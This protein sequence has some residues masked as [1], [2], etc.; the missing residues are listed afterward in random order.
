MLKNYLIILCMVLAILAVWI[1][2]Y[3]II[4]SDSN[5][6]KKNNVKKYK[7]SLKIYDVLVTIPIIG[8][9]ILNIKKSLYANS[10]DNEYILRYKAIVYYLIGWFIALSV[11]ITL[12][13]IYGKNLYITCVLLFISYYLKTI[14]IDKLI[15]DDTKLLKDLI[16]FI[17]DLKHQFHIKSAVSEAMY[18]SIN[19]A[20][21]LMV[22]QGK[23]MYE[24]I[25]DE[26]ALQ[27]Y[28]EECSNKYL[29]IVT[30]YIFLTNEY[31]D[32][33]I[34]GMSVFIK[35]MNYIMKEVML[36]ILKRDQLRYW[37]KALTAISLIPIIFPNIMEK[38]MKNNFPQANFFYSSSLDIIA[39]II[40]LI[41]A[42]VCFIGLRQLEKYNDKQIKLTV[43]EKSW[44]KV[45][46]KIKPIERI[47]HISM[48]K[49]NSSYYHK[50]IN[51]L[52]QAGS[53]LTIEWLYLRRIISGLLGFIFVIISVV[54]LQRIHI[55]NVLNNTSYRFITPSFNNVIVI[56]KDQ[57]DIGKFDSE[58][59]TKVKNEDKIYKTTTENLIKYMREYGIDDDEIL[60]EAIIRIENKLNY[61]NNQYFKWYHIIL[62][63]VIGFFTTD[64]PIWV[65]KF[66]KKLRQ[67][68][69]D[70][71]VFQ[72]Y[73]IILLLM[74]HEKAS[75][76][77]ILEW[78]ERFS[79]I[80]KNPIRKCQ[81]NLQ[82]GTVEALEQL[83]E[84]VK[85]KPFSKIID[86]LIIS[87]K[88]KL[89]EAF[90]SLESEREFFEEE[91]KE[92]N[93]RIV[94]ERVSLGEL[95]GFIPMYVTVVIYFVLPLVW[96]SYIELDNILNNFKI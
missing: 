19:I 2:I 37:L 42:L 18:E 24:A 8:N 91:R 38:W 55:D 41:V 74:H 94:H 32:K 28:Y 31:G 95:L 35:N 36:E 89:W 12:Y 4:K 92:L 60:K 7:L 56:G 11:F 53:Y 51:L 62:A 48:P 71:E 25:E 79:D 57:V 50:A 75:I 77:M 15:G 39:R 63:I 34:N 47:V 40:I 17:R 10:D 69:M 54:A 61:L 93:K 33:R 23:K 3:L 67:A 29:K 78:M 5:K 65:L 82:N 86:N 70:T 85:Y 73:T 45:L 30:G 59:I 96:T 21:P 90:E 87:E 83:K 76:E 52:Q 88:I 81:S 84:D 72:F 16:E 26:D 20:T 64:I 1:P 27:N 6:N 49:P 14:S 9:S 43:K 22:V 46:L 66:Q 13:I 44:E 68:D 58:I 80:F